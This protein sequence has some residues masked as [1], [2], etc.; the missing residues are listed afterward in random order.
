MYPEEKM[1]K[2]EE[3]KMEPRLRKMENLTL[4]T[5]FILLLIKIMN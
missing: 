1:R 3:A 2:Q 5:N 4:D